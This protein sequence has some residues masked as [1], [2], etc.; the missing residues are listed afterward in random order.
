MENLPGANV[1][2]PPVALW[3]D[4]WQSRGVAL[5][6]L[7]RV[8][9]QRDALEALVRAFVD[10]GTDRRQIGYLQYRARR[11]LDIIDQGGRQ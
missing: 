3:R 9:A 1:E 5:D 6:R 7:G 8:S 11:A 2:Y 4:L 10:A